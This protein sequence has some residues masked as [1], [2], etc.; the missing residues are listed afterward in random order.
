V[1]TPRQWSLDRLL[2]MLSALMLCLALGMI[3]QQLVLSGAMFETGEGRFLAAV[4]HVAFFNV[5]GFLCVAWLLKLEGIGWEKGFGFGQRTGFAVGLGLVTATVVTP[6]VMMLQGLLAK[7]LTAEGEQPELQEV[8]KTI[9][10]TVQIEQLFFYGLV[11]I[12]LAPVIEEL[13]FRGIFYPAI[14]S[15][16]RP[17]LALWGTSLMFALVH[18]NML[19]FIPLT[20]LA[21]VLVKLYERTGNLL[22]PILAHCGF[23]TVNFVLLIYREEIMRWL[24][25]D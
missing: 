3:V 13:L 21:V 17:K 23:N 4:I 16:G 20:L 6:V 18:N 10:S 2:Q 22:A 19:T 24:K 11:A 9:E 7:A 25:P 5:G 14:K 8:V 12:V 1:F 15:R